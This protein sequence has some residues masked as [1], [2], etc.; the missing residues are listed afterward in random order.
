MN[1]EEQK[2]Y[3]IVLCTGIY[4]P[5]IGGPA[6]YAKLLKDELPKEGIDVD[7]V[8]FDDVRH[9]P[10]LLRHIV[11]FAK[12]LKIGFSVN[13][14]MAQDTVS[15][16][17]PSALAALVL[18]KPFIVRVPGD[19]A[20]EQG[21]QRFGVADGIDDFQTKRY[22]FMVEML[23][24]IQKWVV[25]SADI[26]IAPSDYFANLVRGWVKK[27][28]RVR[29]IYNGVELPG[30]IDR[31]TARASLG[32]ADDVFVVSTIGR[33]VPWK[34]FSGVIDA[35]SQAVGSENAKLF[36]IGD[37]PQR[38]ALDAQAQA[39][40]NVILTGSVSRD[41][42]LQY[43]AAS[44][45]FV[46]NTSFESFSF[47]IVEAMMLGVPVLSTNICNIPEIVEDGT[48][49]MLVS[50]D[51]IAALAQALRVYQTDKE[52]VHRHGEAGLIKADTFSIKRTVRELAE[53]IKTL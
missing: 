43:L 18:R 51:D 44:D 37:G 39:H 19:Y 25:G 29:R 34:G 4:P 10:K 40:A 16:G 8:T 30:K 9:L 17:M 31:S 38:K 27:P 53:A 48:T 24:R 45:V 32:I 2:R 23:R 20:W 15:V 1:S 26:A 21:K 42:V 3:K 47:Q 13:A 36:I 33:L 11:Y 46:L 5:S 7:V 6:T 49:G 28:E 35:F 50:P 12:V 52:L 14:I 41:Q 22:G